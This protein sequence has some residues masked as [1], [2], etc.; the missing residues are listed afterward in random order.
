[1][2]AKLGLGGGCHWCTEAIFLSLK[3]VLQVDQGFIKSVNSM[4]FSEAVLLEY[5]TAKIGRRDLIEIHLYTH[6]STS[7]HSFREK[8][9]SAVYTFTSSDFSASQEI[10]RSLQRNFEGNLITQVK[11]FAKFK[12]SK[13]RFHNYYFTNPKR[14]FCT[15][16][17]VPKLTLLVQQ[18]SKLV[19]SEKVAS[20]ISPKAIL[21]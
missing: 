3:G 19:D 5:D 10:I 2:K 8:Y 14:P 12:P 6:K 11:E 20:S 9:R 15:T 17:I 21:T 18:Y 13:E 16:Y 7:D 1:M 4:D